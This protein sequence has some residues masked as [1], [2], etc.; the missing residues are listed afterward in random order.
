MF[1]MLSRMFAELVNCL[2]E[3]NEAR[4]LAKLDPLNGAEEGKQLP[5]TPKQKEHDEENVNGICEALKNVRIDIPIFTLI[6]A[7]R[8]TSYAF[9]ILKMRGVR[10]ILKER[11]HK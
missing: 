7:A 2:T 10:S 11:R 3:I 1:S 8:H 9:V 5:V 6:L 4:A